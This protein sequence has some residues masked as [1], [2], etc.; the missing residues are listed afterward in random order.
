MTKNY[1]N[2]LD[3]QIIFCDIKKKLLNYMVLK[4]NKLSALIN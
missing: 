3:E 2:I 4:Q 1:F